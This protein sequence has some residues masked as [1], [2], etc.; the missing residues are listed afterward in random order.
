MVSQLLASSTAGGL[1]VW[2]GYHATFLPPVGGFGGN[3]T[4]P[5]SLHGYRRSLWLRLLL[6]L[7]LLSLLDV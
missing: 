4:T 6:L 7:L 2:S 3:A 5:F 1:C